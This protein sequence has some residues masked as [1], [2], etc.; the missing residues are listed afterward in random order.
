MTRMGGASGWPVEL[1]RRAFFRKQVP[2][3]YTGAPLRH[4]EKNEVGFRRTANPPCLTCPGLAKQELLTL[5]NESRFNNTIFWDT[6][7]L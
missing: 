7:T 6:E 4:F 5:A 3:G 1:R 2:V